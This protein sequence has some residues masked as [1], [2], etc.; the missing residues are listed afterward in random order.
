MTTK[1]TNTLIA[2]LVDLEL[3]R[4]FLAEIK[5]LDGIIQSITELCAEDSTHRYLLPGFVDSHVHIESSMLP[6][7]EF[8][9][10]A[11]RHGTIAVVS[12]PHEIANVLGE[13]GVR[14]MLES[15]R[16]TPFRAYFGAPSCVPATPF[17]T[18][19]GNLGVTEIE[20]LMEEPEVCCLSEMMNFPG[21]LNRDPDVMA[22]IELAQRM[23]LPV[24]GHAP[25]VTGD[26]AA[27]YIQ[28]G[29]STD[30]ECFG[31]EEARYKISQGMHVL[32]REG[33]AARNFD[34][35]HPL[36]SEHPD[37]VMFCSDDKHPDDLLRGHI[38]EM[39]SR[40]IEAGHSLFDVLQCACINPI[41]H[42]RLPMGKLQPGDPMDAIELPDL[43]L[44]QPTRVWLTG[45]LVAREGES[46][47]PSTNCQPVNFFQARALT[48][49]DLEIPAEPSHKIR[50]IT[51][52]DGS[53]MTGERLIE[54]SVVNGAVV[55]DPKRDLLPVCVINRYRP[56]PPALGYIQGF[57]LKSGAIASSVAHD[58]HNIIAVGVNPED[59]CRAVNSIIEQKGGISV[60]KGGTLE[61][62]PLPVAGIMSDLDGE[63]V[64]RRYGELD[65]MARA[66]GSPLS[67][68]FMTLSFMALL[69]IPELKLSDQ[70][71][72]DGRRFKFT[73]LLVDSPA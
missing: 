56:E 37:Q 71:L 47:L 25:G 54:P 52:E 27:R 14:F 31:L 36:I 53:L 20:S 29:I 8:G 34:A 5:W 19:N 24:D 72:F 17:E 6:P 65:R 18:A 30:H 39:V 48:P 33:S 32:I 42:Y 58:S 51:V 57:G 60:V 69:V 28:A 35:L 13:T 21:V 59:I 64:G 43:K 26:E 15:A 11:V 2:N 66:L 23:N 63:Q 16:S 10:L 70:G 62:L 68:P 50:V 73:E 3:R 1:K 61:I 22:K 38:N 49:T 41:N 55:A 67:A 44:F 46:L 7:G 40:A 45:E 12:D 4:I 9:R